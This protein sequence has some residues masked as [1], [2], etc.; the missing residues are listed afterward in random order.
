M[1]EPAAGFGQ[2]VQEQILVVG[3]AAPHA[4]VL[5]DHRLEIL[6]GAGAVEHPAL[7]LVHEV[8]LLV[9]D[10][11]FVDRGVAEHDRRIGQRV[12]VGRAIAMRPAGHLGQAGQRLGPLGRRADHHLVRARRAIGQRHEGRGAVDQREARL[13]PVGAHRHLAPV[14]AVLHRD[15]RGAAGGDAP[16][17]LLG[18]LHRQGPAVGPGRG[19]GFDV[20]RVLPDHVGA[21]RPHRH[22][23]L[24]HRLPAGRHRGRDLRVMRVRRREAE[25]VANRFRGLGECSWSVGHEQRRG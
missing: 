11:E 21:R 22:H 12:E 14:D 20:P 8:V 4:A 15:A 24:G 7:A 2:Q 9:V 1:L 18:L 19:H 16:T 25:G 17:V 23:Q 6:G 3:Q 13:D 5:A 10:R